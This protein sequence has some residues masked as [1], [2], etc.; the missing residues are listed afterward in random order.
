[1]LIVTGGIACG[2]S[3]FLEVARRM[4][5]NCIDADEWFHKFRRSPEEKKFAA[6]MFGEKYAESGWLSEV[7]FVHPNWAQYQEFIDVAFIYHLATQQVV[8][9][10]NYDIVVIPDFFN[11]SA[12]RLLP[13]ALTL[14]IER[15]NNL[16][17]ARLRDGD[18]VNGLTDRIHQN[19]MVSELRVVNARN[20]IYNNLTKS[21]FEKEC[22]EWLQQ[23]L[24][25]ASTQH[26]MDIATS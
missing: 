5:Y 16:E 12:C 7:A 1:M 22:E 24:Q 4:G 9:N 13:K 26:T 14:T 17:A 18:R 19:Q 11:R 20:V 2:K 15:P 6:Q 21:Y 8:H 23:H 10:V 3:T 25:V